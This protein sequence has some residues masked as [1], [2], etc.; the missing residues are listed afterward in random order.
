MSYRNTFGHLVVSGAMRRQSLSLLD[1]I[2]IRLQ[3]L[4]RRLSY[5]TV[6]LRCFSPDARG[7]PF[8]LHRFPEPICSAATIP[9]QPVDI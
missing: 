8:V 3:R 1:M 9:E 5:F 6:F 2:L 7:Y 4:S